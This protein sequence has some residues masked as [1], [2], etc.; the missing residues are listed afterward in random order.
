MDYYDKATIPR[1]LAAL[2]YPVLKILTIV[3][4]IVYHFS[5]LFDLLSSFLLVFCMVKVRLKNQF[6]LPIQI[7]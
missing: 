2:I 6:S 7:Q 3:L 1:L 4:Y 5:V